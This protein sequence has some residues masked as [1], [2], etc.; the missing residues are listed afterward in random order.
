[1]KKIA[2]IGGGLLGMSL[3]YY[4]A[5]DNEV[6]I[7]LYE[8]NAELGGL[9]RCTQID[10]TYLEKYYHHFF[11]SD[12]KV[13]ELIED[14]GLKSEL[15]WRPS[16][17]GFYINGRIHNFSTALDLLKFKPLS[18]IGRVRAG[19]V[20][21]FLQKTKN[22][23]PFEK[24]TALAWCQK[25][26]GKEV[27]E[28][29]WKQLLLGKFGE[30]YYDKV[31][32]AWLWTRLHDRASSRQ[33]LLAMEKLGYPRGSFQIVINALTEKLV[34]LDVDIKLNV[35]H[36]DYEREGD[37]H[38]IDGVEFDNVVATTTP[39]F[40]I[41]KFRPASDYSSKLSK[42]KFTGA[43]CFIVELK[44]SFSNYYWTNIADTAAPILAVIEHTNF[45][46]KGGFNGK[47]ILYLSKYIDAKAPLFNLDPK[48]IFAQFSSYLK[49]INPNYDESWVINYDFYKSAHAQHIVPVGYEVLPYETGVKGLYYGHFCQIYPHDRGENYAVNQ[50]IELSKL[51][52]Q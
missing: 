6:S 42:I 50:A 39:E 34:Q 28:V 37:K 45:V 33:G 49:K 24:V 30:E 2:I 5:R 11:G 32:M 41:E 21:F 43:M 7:T 13:Q 23:K 26:Y 9:A 31:S 1:M 35:A 48:E 38:F 17:V 27:T 12:T 4:L 14:L 46:E 15:E 18:F 36:F 52:M 44:Q 25:Y 8:K 10:G 29:I 40:F 3:A 22:Y 16:H 51:L 47:T 19:L 20:S